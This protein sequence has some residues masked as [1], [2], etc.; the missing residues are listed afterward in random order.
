MGEPKYHCIE[1]KTVS[2]MKICMRFPKETDISGEKMAQE[3]RDILLGV[4]KEG[5]SSNSGKDL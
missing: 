4:L 1:G 3:I 2:G 5:I